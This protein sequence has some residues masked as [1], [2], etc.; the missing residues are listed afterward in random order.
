M[1]NSCYFFCTD[2]RWQSRPLIFPHSQKT[3]PIKQVSLSLAEY[4]CSFSQPHI[5]AFYF[6]V[7]KHVIWLH[8]L[9][10]SHISLRGVFLII[11][12]V[13]ANMPAWV[14][15]PLWLRRKPLRGPEGSNYC[16]VCMGCPA[17]GAS[18]SFLWTSLIWV[19][20]KIPSWVNF[21][22]FPSYSQVL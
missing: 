6:S 8:L 4:F 10:S 19:A 1:K 14:Q 17:G 12:N 13:L 11:N 18:E 15:P 22:P 5:S 7:I 20:H 9:H 2:T 3:N 16:E 21:S